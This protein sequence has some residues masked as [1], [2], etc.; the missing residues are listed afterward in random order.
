MIKTP[1][2]SSHLRVVK[3]SS[4]ERRDRNLFLIHSLRT[5]LFVAVLLFTLSFQIFQK[6]FINFDVWMPVYFVL[7]SCFVFNS[8]FLL[9]FHFFENHDW[10]TGVLLAIDAILITALLNFTGV[11]QSL[12]V[13]LYFVTILLAGLVFGRKGAFLTAFWIG[14]L[15][16]WLFALNPFVAGDG[17]YFPLALNL[18]AFFSVAGL[19]GS[20]SEQIDFMGLRLEES[21]RKFEAL[22]Y[23]NDLIVDNMPSGLITLNKDLTIEF[24]NERAR[25]ILKEQDLIGQNLSSLLPPVYLSLSK[26][27]F[28]D[29]RP[30]LREEL[31]LDIDQQSR[32]LEITTC[33]LRDDEQNQQGYLMIIQDATDVKKMEK[34]LRQKEKLAA[35]GQLAAGIAHE[36][37]NPLAS[38]SGSIQ[39]LVGQPD[40]DPEKAK[41]MNIVLREID[42]LNDL[43]TEFLDYV[44]PEELKQESMDLNVLIREIMEQIRFN[45]SLRQ[46]IKQ[47]LD[48][49]G[50]A[51]ILGNRDKLKQALL[52]MVINSYQAMELIKDPE[53]KIETF[54]E[55][56]KVILKIVDQGIGIPSEMLDRIFEPFHTTKPRGTG[57][58]LAITHKILEAHLAQISVES[59]VNMGTTLR[60]EFPGDFAGLPSEQ[61][62][63]RA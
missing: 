21:S 38:I 1:V 26:F 58:G 47:R 48:L 7:F 59:Q 41:L 61:R 53:L 32:L 16:S 23:L 24:T 60:I 52:N 5:F 40:V 6:N 17:I 50:K 9:G 13:F 37:R 43:I 42:R 2:F 51:W 10:S 31:S 35:V 11:S 36:I 22:S 14:G 34:Q 63:R 19:S 44:R 55:D 46:D 18:A 20:L 25:S 45:K 33:P 15:Y 57:L 28:T 39:L 4:T 27:D 56:G 62:M 49:Q 30:V 3:D 12:F 29:L 8:I 54:D